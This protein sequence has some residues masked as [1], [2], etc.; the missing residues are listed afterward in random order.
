LIIIANSA[1]ACTQAIAEHG[2]GSA[3]A[4]RTGD[5]AC[6]CTR[7]AQVVEAAR[8]E[9]R[10]AASDARRLAIAGALQRRGAAPDVI[11]AGALRRR[12]LAASDAQ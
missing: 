10:V 8:A 12:R 3:C 1:A 2:R 7:L 4:R 9:R 6:S 11:V 5:A